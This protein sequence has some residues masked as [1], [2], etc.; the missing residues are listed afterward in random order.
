[1]KA[2]K[3]H[4]VDLAASEWDGFTLLIFRHVCLLGCCQSVAAAKQKVMDRM[5][6]VGPLASPPMVPAANRWLKVYSPIVYFVLFLVF[7]L[8]AEFG[9]VSNAQVYRAPD[10]I[11]AEIDAIG[12]EDD[13]TYERK[14]KA[15]FKQVVAL[16]GR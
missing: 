4:A 11:I 8:Q 15:R 13:N 10:D 1:M 5:Y 14:T 9:Q 3:E 16:C 6:L 2:R 7:G 12:P